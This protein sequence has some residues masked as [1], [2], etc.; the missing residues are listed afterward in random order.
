MPTTDIVRN[1]TSTTTVT[2]E[3][4]TV[5]TQSTRNIDLTNILSYAIPLSC[6]VIIVV[7]MIT[8]GIRQRQRVLEKWTSLKRMRNTNPRFL[9]TTGLR[10]DSEFD[11]LGREDTLS[12]EQSQESSYSTQSQ[13]QLATIA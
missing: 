13:Y 2:D 7:I 3:Y 4:S 6:L 1:V 5:T 11:S 12:S 8:I 9:Q 10:R